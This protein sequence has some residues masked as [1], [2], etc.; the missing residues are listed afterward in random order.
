MKTFTLF[1]G[2]ILVSTGF[3]Q[4][5]KKADKLFKAEL[6]EE[7]MVIYKKQLDIDPTN[8]NI[9]YKFGSCIVMLN[10]D[11]NMAIEMLII[12][13]KSGKTDKEIAFFLGRAYENKKEYAKAL[14]YYE[15]FKLA[16]DKEQLKKLKVKTRIKACKKALK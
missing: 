1:L 3:S 10:K 12:A 14:E 11:N 8:M 4:D 7:A 13:E 9:G 2:L 15:R 5:I 16:A 6:Y